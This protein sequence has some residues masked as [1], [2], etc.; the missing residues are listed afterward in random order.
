MIYSIMLPYIIP[1]S[2]TIEHNFLLKVPILHLDIRVWISHQI[3]NNEVSLPWCKIT[4]VSHNRLHISFPFPCL[5][6]DVMQYSSRT[7]VSYGIS[8]WNILPKFC[9]S[10]TKL[11]NQFNGGLDENR[12]RL[13]EL[14]NIRVANFRVLSLD[15]KVHLI[16][17]LPH[18]KYIANHN[19]HDKLQFVIIYIYH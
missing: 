8:W 13:W 4:N 14:I 5:P 7:L 18:I 1:W 9:D 17:L 12:Q 6:F 19:Q 11:R 2:C 10:T 3:S 15:K 16:L